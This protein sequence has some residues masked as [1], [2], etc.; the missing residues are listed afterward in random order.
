MISLYMH[1]DKILHVQLEISRYW[2]NSSV[3]IH[4]VKYWLIYYIL[5]SIKK[6]G[7]VNNSKNLTGNTRSSVQPNPQQQPS[8]GSVSDLEVERYGF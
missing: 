3:G 8:V 7:C 6:N 4:R 2:Q 1:Y 5:I